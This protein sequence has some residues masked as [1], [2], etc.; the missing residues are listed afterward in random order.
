LETGKK[1]VSLIAVPAKDIVI[2]VRPGDMYVTAWTLSRG[3]WGEKGFTLY[4]FC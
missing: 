3:F 4:Y 2:T 1:W